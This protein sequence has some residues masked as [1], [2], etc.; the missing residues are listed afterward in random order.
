MKLKNYIILLFIFIFTNSLNTST[1]INEKILNYFSNFKTNTNIINPIYIKIR[2]YYELNSEFLNDS[3]LTFIETSLEYYNINKYIPLELFL[4]LIDTESQFIDNAKSKAGAYGLTQIMPNTEIIINRQY[5]NI[6]NNNYLSR[7]NPYD[8]VTLSILYLKDLLT[9]FNYNLEI[10][11]RFYNGG[12]KW[13]EKPITKSY[14]KTII[15]KTLLL[16]KFIHQNK[17]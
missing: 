14:Y 7:L 12:S 9:R 4:S 15:H 13:R 16:K 8:N 2:D 1:S 6:L 3:F 10:V 11:L 5:A 17:L